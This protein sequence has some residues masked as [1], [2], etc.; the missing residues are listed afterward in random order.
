MSQSDQNT[1][2]EVW[3]WG[4][5]VFWYIRLL[6]DQDIVTCEVRIGKLG[7][8]DLYSTNYLLLQLAQSETKIF[9]C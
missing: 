1:L 6:R 3:F 9:V 2:D 5:G 8:T 7:I 4:F